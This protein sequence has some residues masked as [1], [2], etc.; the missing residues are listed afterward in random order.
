MRG[1]L[2]CRFAGRMVRVGKRRIDRMLLVLALPTVI[3]AL[4][5]TVN[6]YPTDRW[7]ETQ[8]L[9]LGSFPGHDN[10]T[11]IAA[12]ALLY[13]AAYLIAAHAGVGLAGEFYIASVLQN[14]LLLLSAWMIYHTL[15]AMR[16]TQFAA[17]ISIGFLLFIL[18][19]GLP[20]AFWSENATIF[21]MAAVLL[22]LAA[23][24][25]RPGISPSRFWSL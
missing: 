4:G 23:L 18:S 11:P 6:P 24:L 16:F 22:T 17:P 19:T 20:Q 13:H 10:Y 25:A 8:Y 2:R 3:S 7:Y 15:R 1:S 14:L 21:L 5:A 12:P 9:L